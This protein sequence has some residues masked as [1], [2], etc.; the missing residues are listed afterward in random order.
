MIR[1]WKPQTKE[2]IKKLKALGKKQP[3]EKETPLD[4]MRRRGVRLKNAWAR[5]SSH[6]RLREID[7]V[8]KR[9]NIVKIFV[10]ND[11]M[12]LFNAGEKGATEISS[13]NTDKQ[14]KAY[15]EPY[16]E[17]V[18]DSKTKYYKTSKRKAPIITTS[19]VTPCIVFL[20]YTLNKR[21]KVNRAGVFHSHLN[22]SGF[23]PLI[24]RVSKKERVYVKI[25]GFSNQPK[26][27]KEEKRIRKE[28]SKLGKRVSLV[29]IDLG[30]PPYRTVEVYP[31]QG[32]IRTYWRKEKE[33]KTKRI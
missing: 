23:K 22:K 33:P 13:I 21:G 6:E 10:D 30:G 12:A 31:M 9:G 20:A 3:T 24:N 5:L 26:K 18:P 28:L 27:E 1:K 17:K 11:G 29:S 14:K 8:R 2:I 4:K 32:E 7:R 19:V 25:A 15:R 16:N